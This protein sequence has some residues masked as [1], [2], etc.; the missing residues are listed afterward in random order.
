MI[1]FVSL[2]FTI[3]ILSFP[4]SPNSRAQDL[5]T[6]LASTVTA[7]QRALFDF[8]AASNGY[9]LSGGFNTPG[10]L[11]ALLPDGDLAYDIEQQIV[12]QLA[13]NTGGQLYLFDIGASG[14]VRQILPNAFASPRP[15][16]PEQPRIVPSSAD[17][18]TL[19]MGSDSRV[20]VWLALVLLD[21]ILL[22]VPLVG[23][24]RFGEVSGGALGLLAYLAEQISRDLRM[25]FALTVFGQTTPP[26]RPEDV[27]KTLGLDQDQSAVI[28]AR[29]NDLGFDVG[30][31]DGVFGRNTR[32]GLRAWQGSERLDETGYLNAYTLRRLLDF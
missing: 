31:I 6:Q 27:E 13:S 21:D 12:W 30:E 9:V 26:L 11:I 23:D 16:V 1:R 10:S 14:S 3:L 17:G 4:L 8:F 29:L 7:P 20:Q 32:T 25:E 5:A 28:Q 24:P 2:V 22:E 18:V 15:L 19:F